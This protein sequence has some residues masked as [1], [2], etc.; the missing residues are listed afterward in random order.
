MSFLQGFSET[1]GKAMP[2]EF[3]KLN[4]Y[5]KYIPYVGQAT[6]AVAGV[7]RAATSYGDTGDAGTAIGATMGGIGKSRDP[8]VYGSPG[9]E[10]NRD[11]WN[12]LGQSGN[13]LSGDPSEAMSSLD[14]LTGGKISQK[15][16]D[17]PQ[18]LSKLGMATQGEQIK[19]QATAAFNQLS[20]LEE[21][22]E[23]MNN[24][25]DRDSLLKAIASLMSLKYGSDA[26]KGVTVTSNVPVR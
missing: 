3:S 10:P 4:A 9:A 19:T 1:I 8:G 7:D 13:L 26:L 20:K 6:E 11:V 18:L 21:F 12:I 25:K 16:G 14:F 17:A 5:S 15:T 22:K 24:Q 2:N 23:Y